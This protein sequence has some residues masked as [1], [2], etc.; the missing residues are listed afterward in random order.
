MTAPNKPRREPH[1]PF[2]IWINWGHN[3]FMHLMVCGSITAAP[4]IDFSSHAATILGV[5][6]NTPALVLDC[7]ETPF[8]TRKYL[9]LSGHRGLEP[10]VNRFA[11]NIAITPEALRDNISTFACPSAWTAPGKPISFDVILGPETALPRFS[12]L[13][14]DHFAEKLIRQ[15]I[16]CAAANYQVLIINCKHNLATIW[17]QDLFERC[18]SL[19]LRFSP[20]HFHGKFDFE[21]NP[22]LH[23]FAVSRR[24]FI[25]DNNDRVT[26]IYSYSSTDL[27]ASQN[28]FSSIET[29]DPS[30]RA[31]VSKCAYH[32]LDRL[33][34]GNL[35]KF[36]KERLPK[37]NPNIRL[38]GEW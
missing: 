30:C 33:F 27:L 9:G 7:G 37:F 28:L 14:R 13:F 23:H 19:V 36:I 38:R 25:P 26:C 22:D 20:G 15:L 32:F 2:A 6:D 21:G 34:S 29:S 8:Q 3:S 35:R 4:S 1:F 5:L 24:L 31:Y 11:E 16:A 12:N 10:L 17:S 18:D